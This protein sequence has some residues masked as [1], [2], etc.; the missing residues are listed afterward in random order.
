MSKLKW[1]IV[2]LMFVALTFVT[3]VY[4]FLQISNI[5][6]ID[7]IYLDV[8]LGDELEISLDGTNFGKSIDYKEFKF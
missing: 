3:S 1:L 6:T 4:A 7:D 8:R 2:S 5:N